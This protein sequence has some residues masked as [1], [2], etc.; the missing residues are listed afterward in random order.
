MKTVWYDSGLAVRGGFALG[1]LGV[2]LVSLAM[3]GCSSG[4]GSDAGTPGFLTVEASGTEG[5]RPTNAMCGE[6]QIEILWADETTDIGTV[7]VSNDLDYLYVTYNTSASDWAM[8]RGHVH[9]GGDATDYPGYEQGNHGP[10]FGD[11][12]HVFGDP[13]GPAFEEYTIVI[14]FDHPSLL[15]QY[16][17]CGMTFYIFA[18]AT[19]AQIDDNGGIIRQGASWGGPQANRTDASNWMYY[20]EYTVQCCGWHGNQGEFRT[21][22][23]GGWGT[24]CHGWNPGCYRDEWFD[25]AFPDGVTIGCPGDGETMTFTS[26]DAVQEFVPTGG[27][28]GPLEFSYEDPTESAKTEAGVLASQLLALALTL[29]FDVADPDFGS[30]GDLLADQV[31][32]DTGNT[33]WDEMEL[34]VQDLFDEANLVLGACEGTLELKAGELADLLTIVNENYVDGQ[35][36]LGFLCAP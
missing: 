23:Q 17:D 24:V 3:S 16:G 22:S 19:S 26:S 8:R 34:T 30:S 29:G 2:V 13:N 6:E 14:P 36:D 27:K 32:C 33:D 11:F 28:P 4:G 7:E 20:I 31:I 18:Y 1:V 9:V 10:R 5:I 25:I 35:A 12:D 21:Q 15:L